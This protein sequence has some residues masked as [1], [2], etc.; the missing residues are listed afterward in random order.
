MAYPNPS[1]NE[2]RERTSP[3][4]SAAMMSKGSFESSTA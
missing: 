4:M 1:P 2:A 3:V